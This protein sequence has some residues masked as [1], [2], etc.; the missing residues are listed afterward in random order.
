MQKLEQLSIK[1]VCGKDRFRKGA[2]KFDYFSEISTVSKLN[3]TDGFQTELS[4]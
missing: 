2:T 1:H 3:K 4:P